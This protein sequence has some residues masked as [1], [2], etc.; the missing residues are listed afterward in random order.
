ME[1][2]IQVVTFIIFVITL[3]AWAVIGL[4][5]WIPILTR[6]TT[7]FSGMILYAT[8]THQNADALREYLRV[9]SGFYADGFRLTKEALYPPKGSPS[10]NAIDIHAGRFIM[11]LFW[12]SAFWLFILWIGE[13]DLIRPLTVRLWNIAEGF[14]QLVTSFQVLA[15]VIIIGLIL[16]CMWGA[17]LWQRYNYL[18]HSDRR[19]IKA[20]AESDQTIKIH[21]ILKKILLSLEELST[22]YQY[23]N[24]SFQDFSKPV[25]GSWARHDQSSVASSAPSTPQQ[26]TPEKRGD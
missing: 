25:R 21:T 3:T 23:L 6:A 5:F 2:T 16:L 13:P 22:S 26:P 7:V 17:Y 19:W 8:L 11:E 18:S 20:Q 14:Q 9:A 4:V 10:P 12:T 24:R 1:L 15:V